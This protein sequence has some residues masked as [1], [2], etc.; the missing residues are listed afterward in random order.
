FPDLI[1]VRQRNNLTAAAVAK[2]SVMRIQSLAV[3]LPKR[4]VTNADILTEIEQ[5]STHFTGDL[6]QTLRHIDRSLKITG[7]N[8]RYW[9]NG[10]GETSLSLTTDACREAL[11][12][13]DGKIDLIICASV[14]GELVEPATSNLIAH[15]LGL[16]NVECVDVKEA[17]DGWMKAMKIADALIKTGTYERILV[18]NGEFSMTKGY[19]I[20]PG[21]FDLNSA[22]ELQWRFPIF[23]IGEGATATVVEKDPL[24]PWTFS[25]KTRNDLFDLCTVAPTWHKPGSISPR[26]GKDGPGFFTSWASELT[27]H[28]VPLAI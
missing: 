20:N 3:A 22:D 8:V 23:T 16:D 14:F 12:T 24:R 15:E 28:G 26:V 17:C 11:S 13:V 19:A 9:V 2:G 21:L 1:I 18:V 27:G 5:A 4:K 10:S 7:S 6:D 25:N